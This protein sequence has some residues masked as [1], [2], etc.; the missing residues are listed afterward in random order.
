MGF[1]DIMLI[2]E[3]NSEWYKSVKKLYFVFLTLSYHSE[4]NS[5]ISI[6]SLNL[7]GSF[8]P[9]GGGGGA[10]LFCKHGIETTIG[11]RPIMV[12]QS[13]KGIFGPLSHLSA[14]L[15]LDSPC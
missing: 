6:I 5:N 13:F 8:P 2:L 1:R 15:G 12:T 10:D 14:N 3:L 9:F 11:Q 7:N 4:F